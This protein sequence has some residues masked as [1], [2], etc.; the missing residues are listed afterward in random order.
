MLTTMG[1]VQSEGFMLTL[2]AIQCSL[3]FDKH[4]KKKISS[5]LIFTFIPIKILT[6]ILIHVI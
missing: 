4:Q 3:S 6:T 5:L 2:L 1:P